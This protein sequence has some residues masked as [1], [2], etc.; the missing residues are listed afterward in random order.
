MTVAAGILFQTKGTAEQP[1]QVLF[2]KRGAGSDF[3]G[4]WCFPGGHLEEGETTEEC[5]EREAREELGKFPKGDKREWTR[6]ITGTPIDAAVLQ[7]PIDFTTFYQRVEETFEPQLNGEHVGYAWAPADQPP[8]PLHPGCQIALDRLTMNEL[9][10][11]EAIRDG[12]LTSPQIYENV[13][14]F[15][16]RITGTGLA[17][18]KHLKE[19]VWREPEIYLNDDFLRRCN[20][21][22]VIFEHPKVSML[23]SKEFNDRV[24]G[25]ILL[26]YLQPGEVWG[27]AKI[28][29]AAAIKVMRERQ[30]STSPG[31]SWRDLTVNAVIKQDDGSTLLIEGEPSLVDH[32]AICM[33]GVWDKDGPPTGVLNET[34]ERI[35]MA[36]EEKKEPAE[37]RKDAD[38]GTKLDKILSHQDSI[39]ERLDALCGRMDSF[40]EK[41]KSRAD[42]E[43]KARMDARKDA[44]ESEKKEKEEAEKKDAR[45]DGD[46]QASA[47][48]KR[49]DAEKA[50]AEE[51]ERKDAARHDSASIEEIRAEVE[52]V[53]RGMP[54]QITDA[55]HRELATAQ[56]R[57]DTAYQ[58]FGEHAGRPLQSE[59]VQEYRLRM[60]RGLQEHSPT[61]KDS[62]LGVVAV[63]S[64]ALNNAESMILAEARR[65]ALDPSK[66]AEYEIRPM[67]RTDSTGRQV[68]EFFGR[69]SFI[70]QL[71]PPPMYITRFG[72]E[73]TVN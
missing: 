10:V 31:V 33:R 35:D 49:K 17:F 61:W 44:E 64:A 32:I 28:Y 39:S 20:G 62:N 11:A 47:M 26:P 37:D 69:G 13:A 9:G 58:A 21:L 38:M 45:K 48:D 56:A 73:R 66:L 27:I 72:A 40:D 57:F 18:R 42:A 19:F 8:Q 7:E 15:A 68:T 65:T 67:V 52:K 53:K 25:T 54:T 6:A 63:D 23:N 30:L 12:R 60:L 46:D 59:S 51:K 14:L 3:P 22:A 71:T 43:E 16:I 24:V 29:D 5:A 4:A 70:R 50:E 36:A 34:L 41:E 2:L 55:E 1:A